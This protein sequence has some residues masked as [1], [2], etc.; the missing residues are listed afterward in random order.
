VRKLAVG[1]A[2]AWADQ[3]WGGPPGLPPGKAAEAAQ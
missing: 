1:V 2:H 3:Q